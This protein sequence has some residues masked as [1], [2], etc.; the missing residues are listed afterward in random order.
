M[1]SFDDSQSQLTIYALVFQEEVDAAEKKQK[2]ENGANGNGA[3]TNGDAEAE[4]EEEEG[5]VE[6]E[7]EEEDLGEEEEGE[8][9]EGEEDLDDEAEGEGEGKFLHS[10]FTFE[11]KFVYMFVYIFF[12]RG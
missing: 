8:D 4:G 9:E 5:D 10:L 11:E 12:C 3:A 6:G 2:T 7:D 1:L